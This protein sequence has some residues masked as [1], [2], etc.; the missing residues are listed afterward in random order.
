MRRLQRVHMAF[1]FFFMVTLREAEML[2]S[3]KQIPH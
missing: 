3:R 1:S 2:A